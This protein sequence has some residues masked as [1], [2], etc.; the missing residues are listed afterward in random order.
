[1]WMS[2]DWWHRNAWNIGRRA[3]GAYVGYGDDYCGGN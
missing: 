1:M 2:I 3:F